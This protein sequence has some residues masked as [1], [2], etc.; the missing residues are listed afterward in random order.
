MVNFGRECGRGLWFT[1]RLVDL[2]V[3]MFENA[4]ATAVKSYDRHIV[5]LDKSPQDCRAALESLLKKALVAYEKRPAGLRHGI[6]LD[7]QVTII[8]SQQDDADLPLCGIYFN[9][10][11]PYRKRATATK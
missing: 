5:C 2:S 6:A 9:L 10:H 1:L 8:L 3:D 7:P 4:I 11:T